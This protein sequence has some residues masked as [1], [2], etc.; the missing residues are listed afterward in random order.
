MSVCERLN[1]QGVTAPLDPMCRV[2]F[3]EVAV[4]ADA[5][6]YLVGLTG[7]MSKRAIGDRE[8]SAAP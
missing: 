2:D 8:P 6:F 4:C 3:I 7:L 5:I 1:I